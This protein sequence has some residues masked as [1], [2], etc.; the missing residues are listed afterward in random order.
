[1]ALLYIP[2]ISTSKLKISDGDKTA[3]EKQ[4]YQLAAKG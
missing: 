3:I 4:A 2:A 1:M